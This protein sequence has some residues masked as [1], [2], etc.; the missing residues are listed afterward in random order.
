MWHR[1]SKSREPPSGFARNQRAESLMNQ[2]RFLLD[3][4][5]FA[6]FLHQSVIKD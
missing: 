3:G 6:G 5:E 1:A 4:R 2:R